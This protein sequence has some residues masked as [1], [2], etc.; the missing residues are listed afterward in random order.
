MADSTA[1]AWQGAESVRL[2][3]EWTA[4]VSGTRPDMGT[5]GGPG[6]DTVGSHCRGLGFGQVPVTN[7]ALPGAAHLAA[8]ADG[9]DAPD[10]LGYVQLCAPARSGRSDCDHAVRHP[11][12]RLGGWH[13][14]THG[15]GTVLVVV[16]VKAS[17]LAVAHLFPA[18]A[19]PLGLAAVG[20]VASTVRGPAQRPASF[21][22]R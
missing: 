22:S 17:T 14:L 19:R 10:L 15:A 3:K 13:R 20:V 7:T 9:F 6:A 4:L 2:P 5:A 11:Q 16:T 18:Q 12:R 8:D 21:R 1:G